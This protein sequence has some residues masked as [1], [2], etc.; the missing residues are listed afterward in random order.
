[1]AIADYINKHYGGNKAAF[2]RACDV[3][4]QQITQWVNG[5]YIVVDGTLYSPRRKLVRAD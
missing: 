2:A 3:L 4:P 5:G 1:M